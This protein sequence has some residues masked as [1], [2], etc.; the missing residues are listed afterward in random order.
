MVVN[1]EAFCR[2]LVLDFAFAGML[3]CL[4]WPW[5]DSSE[6]HWRNFR[7]VSKFDANVRLRTAAGTSGGFLVVLR[8]L[9]VS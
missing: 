2:N 9:P 1:L 6:R 5:P 7:M 4:R 8:L 3:F